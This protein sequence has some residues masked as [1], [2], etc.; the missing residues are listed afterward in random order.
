MAS[1]DSGAAPEAVRGGP[2]TKVDGNDLICGVLHV[3]TPRRRD[4]GGSMALLYQ[5]LVMGGW[6]KSKISRECG[7]VSVERGKSKKGK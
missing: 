5:L 3:Q 7:A 6:I 2:N 1:L 4:D